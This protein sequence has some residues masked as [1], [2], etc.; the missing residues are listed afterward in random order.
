VA[1]TNPSLERK[2]SSLALRGRLGG[3]GWVWRGGRDLFLFESFVYLT[4]WL[5][6]KQAVFV[7]FCFVVKAKERIKL[8]QY[9]DLDGRGPQSEEGPEFAEYI[10]FFTPFF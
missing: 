1:A 4:Q 9:N 2:P 3:G 10:F 8:V 7:L 5:N 6:Y